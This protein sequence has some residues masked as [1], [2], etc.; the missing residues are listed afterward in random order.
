MHM[1]SRWGVVAGVWAVAFV[2]AALTDLDIVL[3]AAA[4]CV[5]VVAATQPHL[6]PAGI[7]LEDL[8]EVEARI[9]DEKQSGDKVLYWVAYTQGWSARD[10][11]FGL[12]K[13]PMRPV[14]DVSPP[15]GARAWI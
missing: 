5:T 6:R 10:D 4:A 14:P 2:G 8:P 7:R 9:M 1:I 15:G 11:G 12:D 3:A 13:Q